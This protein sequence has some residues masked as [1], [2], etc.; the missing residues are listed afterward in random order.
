M[1]TRR[2]IHFIDLPF[3]FDIAE[4]LYQLVKRLM[5]GKGEIKCPVFCHRRK[6][7]ISW[8]TLFTCL[9]SNTQNKYQLVYT[10]R[11]RREPYLP[12]T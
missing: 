9:P 11:Y 12:D 1:M 5:E 6:I 7:S 4:P 3:C 10:D 8:R 2:G